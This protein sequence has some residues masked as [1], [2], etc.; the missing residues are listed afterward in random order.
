[1][2]SSYLSQGHSRVVWKILSSCPV[3]RLI[4]VTA[5]SCTVLLMAFSMNLPERKRVPQTYVCSPPPVAHCR[6]SSLIDILV[7]LSILM[8]YSVTTASFVTYVVREHQTKAKQLQHISG[9]SV[10]CYWV[11]NFIY[12]MVSH[13]VFARKTG[14]IWIVVV[15]VL[16]RSCLIF[17]DPMDCSTTDFPSFTVSQTFLKLMSIESMMPS[18]HLILWRSLLLLPSIFPS[19]KVFS[20][21][22]ALLIKWPK[23]SSFIFSISPS[24]KYSELISFRADW[25]D[26]L[27]VQGTVKSLLQHHS[28]KASILQHSAF[29]IVQL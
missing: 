27:A 11:T 26:R 17:C 6:M 18:N 9:I 12:D 24:N 29:F 1:M 15:Q 25:F 7:A 21:E 22:S 28:A 2:H 3:G 14:L 8:G 20:S 5:N 13:C 10:T 16:S 23:Y 19:I 4:C